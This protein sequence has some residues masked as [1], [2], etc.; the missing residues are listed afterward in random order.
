VQSTAVLVQTVQYSRQQ[1]IKLIITRNLQCFD[2]MAVTASTQII[3]LQ[4]CL[5]DD[6]LQPGV[7]PEKAKQKLG[8][9]LLI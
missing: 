7:T 4:G 8:I 6:L 3:L 9:L 2:M 5:M 1:L